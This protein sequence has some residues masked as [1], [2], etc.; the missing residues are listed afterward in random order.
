MADVGEPC[1]VAPVVMHRRVENGGC[2]CVSLAVAM[3]QMV[4]VLDVG[5]AVTWLRCRWHVKKY[6]KS[7]T[8]RW[9]GMESIQW[10]VTL[11]ETPL[12]D[13]G[14][15]GCHVVAA[16]CRA[17][18][19][20]TTGSFFLRIPSGLCLVS[21]EKYHGMAICGVPADKHKRRTCT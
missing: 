12:G 13:A 16:G 21:E 10:T 15:A 5:V 8:S 1:R 9:N 7:I 18:R 11:T 2:R 17:T 19:C 6:H 14:S 3:L 4:L 20:A